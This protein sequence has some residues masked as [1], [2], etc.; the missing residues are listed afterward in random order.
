MLRVYPHGESELEL[1]DPEGADKIIGCHQDV[2]RKQLVLSLP[3]LEVSYT[4]QIKMAE[5]PALLVCD[6]E[7]PEKRDFESFK[8]GQRGWYWD[9]RDK[10]LYIKPSLFR[11]PLQLEINL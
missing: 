3:G 10:L 8:E 5:K 11:Q 7:L 4:L 2:A 6:E 9:A 1:L